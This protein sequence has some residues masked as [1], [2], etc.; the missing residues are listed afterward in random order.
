MVG[1]QLVGET[2]GNCTWLGGW[3]SEYLGDSADPPCFGVS[4]VDRQDTEMSHPLEQL[5]RQGALDVG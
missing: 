3:R 5:P 2:G 1:A 4:A